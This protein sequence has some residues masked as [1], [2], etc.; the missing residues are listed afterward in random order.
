[1]DTLNKREEKQAAKQTK[2]ITKGDYRVPLEEQAATWRWPER[3]RDRGLKY[4]IPSVVWG[5]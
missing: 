1:V 4:S 3:K 5:S 2:R